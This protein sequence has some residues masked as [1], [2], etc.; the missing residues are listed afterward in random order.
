MHRGEELA[1]RRR[2][3]LDVVGGAEDDESGRSGALGLAGGVEP[4]RGADAVRHESR[5]ARQ[6]RGLVRGEVATVLAAGEVD[7]A[8]DTTAGHERRAHLERDARCVEQLAVAG[9][10]LGTAVGRLAEDPDR[11]AAG[12]EAPRMC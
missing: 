4:K 9:A 2:D 3:H 11:D 5:H 10:S 12:G 7:R 8:P 6:C 1:G